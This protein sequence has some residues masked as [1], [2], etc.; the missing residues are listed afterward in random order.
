METETCLS[1]VTKDDTSPSDSLLSQG[2]LDGFPQVSPLTADSFIGSSLVS[3]MTVDSLDL[4]TIMEDVLE[5]ETVANPRLPEAVPSPTESEPSQHLALVPYLSKKPENSQEEEAE[6]HYRWPYSNYNSLC[7]GRHLA[8]D[9]FCSRRENEFKAPGSGYSTCAPWCSTP[10]SPKEASRTETEPTGVGAGL[11]NLGNT[12]FINAV[13]QCFTHTVPFVLGLRSLNHHE[14]SCDHISSCFQRY[15]QEDAHEFLQCLLNK[16]ESCFSDSKPKDDCLSSSDDCLVKKVFGGRLVS[17]LCCCNCGHI[18]YSYEPLNDLSLEIEDVDTLPCALESFT[19]V[20]KIDDLEAKFRCENCKEEVSVEKQFMLDQAPSV[21]TFHLKRFKTEG[22]FVEKIDKHV[23]FPLELDL[24]PYTIVNQTSK[25]ELKYQLYAVVK[26]SGFRPT[27]GHYVCYIRSSPDMWHKLNDSRVTGVDEEAVLSQEAY[28]LFYARQG[29]PWFSS[30]IE[31]Q[32]PCA[33]PGIADSSPISVL[34]NIECASIPRGENSADCSV[35]E[36]KDGTDKTSTRSSCETQFELEI[37]EPCLAAERISG[38][39]VN[40]SE[41]HVLKSIDTRDDNP[42]NG[43]FI[44]PESINC[45]D[46]FEKNIFTLSHHEEKNSNQGVDEATNDSSFPSMPSRSQCS[47]KSCQRDPSGC[48]PCAHL[49]EEKRGIHQRA[50]NRPAMDQGRIEAMRYAKRM[51]TGRGAKFMALLASQTT[52][53][54]KKIT[55]SSP[56][57]RV[58]PR[59]RHNQNLMRPVPVSR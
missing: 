48:G 21:A 42:M 57:K 22:T 8:C 46:E 41:F 15:Q 47:D 58:C 20:E 26:H 28:I 52:G 59:R 11:E 24:Q 37:D 54:M 36:S 31:V 13:L 27:S 30:A 5:E 56:C 10:L 18:S 25:E 3:P 29:I 19:K 45:S 44:P 1:K 14:K 9:Q 16:L 17:R 35:N 51:P 32:K 38:L 12:C 55:G 2:N 43:A 49:K 4:E 34:D 7:S 40:E 53:K 33:D 6:Y 50:V 23:V 39:P